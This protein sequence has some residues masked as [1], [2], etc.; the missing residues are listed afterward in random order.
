MVN[1][2]NKMFKY[3]F[4]DW[5]TAKDAAKAFY[6]HVWK[7]HGLFN[8][9]IFD[10]GPPFVNHFLEQLITSLGKSAYFSTTYHP[11][12]DNQTEIMNSAFEQYFKAYMN[13]FQDDLVL[14]LPSAEFVINNHASET[15][16]WIFFNE[17]GTVF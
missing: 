16:Q 6:I 15:T 13:Y 8:F 5:I 11:E 4:M 14:W 12:I 17:F 1:R 3:I 9:I 7:N 2:L 10:R